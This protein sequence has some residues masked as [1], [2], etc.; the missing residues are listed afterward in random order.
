MIASKFKGYANFIDLTCTLN[1]NYQ[2]S[3][4]ECYIK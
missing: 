1:Q 3:K 2:S 4:Y